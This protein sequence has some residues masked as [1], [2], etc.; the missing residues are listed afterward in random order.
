M[1]ATDIRRRAKLMIYIQ[2]YAEKYS[3]NGKQYGQKYFKNLKPH[4]I[5][6]ILPICLRCEEPANPAPSE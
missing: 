4:G 6:K 3:T 5:L 2:N 1:S